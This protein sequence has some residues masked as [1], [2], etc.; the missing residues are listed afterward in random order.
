[1]RVV[2]RRA[3][4]DSVHEIA[5]TSFN[6]LPIRMCV[7]AV[8]YDLIGTPSFRL[9]WCTGRT[10]IL[11]PSDIQSKRSLGHSSGYRA[12]GRQEG[13]DTENRAGNKT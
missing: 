5:P 6:T 2:G 8:T 1:M 12:D 10:R 13:R 4:K 7:C 9:V 3:H 11:L